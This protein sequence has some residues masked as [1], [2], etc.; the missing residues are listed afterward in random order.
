MKNQSIVIK[1]ISSICGADIVTKTSKEIKNFM[2]SEY[3]NPT[4]YTFVGF[5]DRSNYAILVARYHNVRDG[6]G[7]FTSVR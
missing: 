4:K 7:R 1:N 2:V 3:I 6:K 5:I